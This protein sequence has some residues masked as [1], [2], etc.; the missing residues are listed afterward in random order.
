MTPSSRHAA[1]GIGLALVCALFWG[2][3]PVALMLLLDVM[4][5]VTL[6]ALRFVFA[7][8]VL[9]ALMVG[10]RR[11]RG[12]LQGARRDWRWLLAAL[13]GLAGNFLLFLV[14]L[15]YASP[16]VVQVVG[17]LG[18]VFLLFGGLWCFGE[19]LSRRQWLGVW[20]L[21]AGLL[22]FFNRRL[23]ELVQWSEG[24]GLGVGLALGG[25]ALWALYGLSQKRLVRHL[26]PQQV[27]VLLY[28]VSALLLWPASAPAQVLDLQ[29]WQ[30]PLLMFACINTLVA[31]GAF[32]ESLRHLEA[33]RVGAIISVTPLVTAGMAAL[34]AWLAP[35]LAVPEN[36]N[37]WS[38]LGVAMVVVGS[39]AVALGSAAKH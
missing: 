29:G 33:S 10:M 25:A 37:G 21:L 27:L 24:F 6:T 9:G 35:G 19:R 39:A 26:Q 38:L 13:L 23:G 30:W 36:L 5:P 18:A 22:L 11:L 3:L 7:A 16:T 32:A 28:P 20:L 17:Q 12:T 4:D 1:L 34:A 14:A 2:M 8:A 15:R 31:Y